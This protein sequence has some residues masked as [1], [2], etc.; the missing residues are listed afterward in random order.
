MIGIIQKLL[1]FTVALPIRW[2]RS[3]HE[4]MN[5]VG[6]TMMFNFLLGALSIL[7]V[8]A[9]MAWVAD[10]LLEEFFPNDGE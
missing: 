5:W 2:T 8:F 10:Y 1:A 3:A 6:I 4:L 9:F 7:G